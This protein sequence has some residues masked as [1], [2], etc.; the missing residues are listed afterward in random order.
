[1]MVTGSWT[2]GESEIGDDVHDRSKRALEKL[3]VPP[4]FVSIETLEE[5]SNQIYVKYDEEDKKKH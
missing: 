4:E 1:M 3:F 5:G 2:E